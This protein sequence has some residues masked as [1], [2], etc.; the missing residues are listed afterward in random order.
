MNYTIR[1]MTETHMPIHKRDTFTGEDTRNAWSSEV[2]HGRC[3]AV[4]RKRR[5][6]PCKL[7]SGGILVTSHGQ[8]SDHRGHPW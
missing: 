6:S 3:C 2:L 5:G 4:G 7:S 1:E 8:A